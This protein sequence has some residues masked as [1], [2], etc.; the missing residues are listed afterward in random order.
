MVMWKEILVFVFLGYQSICDIRTRKINAGVCMVFGAAGLLLLAIKHQRNVVSLVG[1][2]VIGVC[3]MLVSYVTR[4][5]IGMGD[6]YVVTAVGIWAGGE[7]TLAA[8]MSA[9]LLAAGFGMV[10]IA[11]GKADK[12]TELAFVPFLTLSYVL[13]I[14][15]K[16]I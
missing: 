1:G 5:A 3:L 15:G 4:E 8:M 2:C 6:G 14:I 7:K 10:K 13:V 11:A 16:A 12:K 9:F